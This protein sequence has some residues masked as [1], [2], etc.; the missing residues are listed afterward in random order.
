MLKT[1]YHGCHY[2]TADSWVSVEF[3]PVPLLDESMRAVLRRELEAEDRPDVIVM[4]AG[5]WFLIMNFLGTNDPKEIKQ[6]YWERLMLL[7]E[8]N[9]T[10]ILNL[11]LF[12]YYCIV[13]SYSR[14]IMGQQNLSGC[15][16]LLSGKPLSGVK[17]TLFQRPTYTGNQN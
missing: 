9:E 15:F 12:H 10:F 3:F 11:L 4:S 14:D 2:K 13:F 5:L 16:S 1:L 8:V 7:R 6:I 17:I